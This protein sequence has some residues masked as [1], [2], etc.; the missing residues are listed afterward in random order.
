MKIVFMNPNSSEAM[1]QSILSVAHAAAAPG[2]QVVGW[3][4]KNGPPSIQGIEDGQA[5]ITG[6]LAGLQSDEVTNADAIVIACFEDVG[7]SDMQRA[8]PCPVIG[9][10]QASYVMAELLGQPFSVVTSVAASVPVIEGNIACRGTASHCVSVRASGLPV[11][12]IEEGTEK[13]RQHLANEIL[14]A[15]ERDGARTIVLG[16]AGMATM[17]KDLKA[18]TGMVLIEG[19]SAAVALCMSVQLFAAV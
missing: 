3:T 7:L 19:V 15:N 14:K 1:T 8:A 17:H 4:N 2:V 12:T 16:C 9:I 18:R 10:G 5:A 11:L 13:T 6:L